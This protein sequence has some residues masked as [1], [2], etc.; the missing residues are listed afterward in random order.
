[1][2]CHAPTPPAVFVP[3]SCFVLF[4]VYEQDQI[5]RQDCNDDPVLMW[6][7]L[8]VHCRVCVS[9]HVARVSMQ[10]GQFNGPDAEHAPTVR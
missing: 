10:A 1:M 3:T 9:L 7:R 4:S 5:G 8:S 2:L 6:S